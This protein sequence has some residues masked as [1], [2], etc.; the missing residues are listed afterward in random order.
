MGQ[1]L[2]STE[3]NNPSIEN[4]PNVYAELRSN[5]NLREESQHQ[6]KKNKFAP[7]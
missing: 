7:G 6:L 4:L 5:Y 1:A 3:L 2:R